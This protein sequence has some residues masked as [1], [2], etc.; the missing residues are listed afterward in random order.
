MPGWRA[1]G[2]LLADGR[3]PSGGH[4]HSNAME[5]AVDAGLVVDVASLEAFLR[6]RLG[7]TGRIDAHVAAAAC[8]IAGGRPAPA[9]PTEIA[10]CYERLD[11]ELDARTVSLAAR[12]VSRRQGSQYLRAAVAVTPGPALD[13]LAQCFP[14]GPH[15]AIVLGAAGACANIEPVEMARL[16]A[17]G[18]VAGPSTAAVRLLGLDPTAASTVLARLMSS[19]DEIAEEARDGTLP[20]PIAG[21]PVLD[22]LAES[23]RQRRERLFAS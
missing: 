6:G 16:A 1:L 11:A 21:A 8:R 2:L 4:A 5:Q 14:A 15:L 19:C 22:W 23:H 20:L 3:L 13:L 12:V 10:A 18:A 7:T 17:Y 9:P